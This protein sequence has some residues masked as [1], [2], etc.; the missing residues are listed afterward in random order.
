MHRSQYCLQM[1]RDNNW[2]VVIK[3]TSLCISEPIVSLI[4]QWKL[5][6]VEDLQ[7]YTR[8]GHNINTSTPFSFYILFSFYIGPFLTVHSLCLF[9]CITN[10]NF[11]NAAVLNQKCPFQHNRQPQDKD[12]F[13]HQTSP[14]YNCCFLERWNPQA[15]AIKVLAWANLDPLP[16][17]RHRH[18]KLSRAVPGMFVPAPDGKYDVYQIYTAMLLQVKEAI[19]GGFH[20]SLLVWQ[21][22]VFVSFCCCCGQDFFVF[23]VC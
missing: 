4:H 5:F 6:F 12:V 20:L 8:H 2:I 19:W 10:Y 1:Q 23:A 18:E 7:E 3:C 11:V 16:Y 14:H 9:V 15:S 22:Y 21:V 13:T 17:L